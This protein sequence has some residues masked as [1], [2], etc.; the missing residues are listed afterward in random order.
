M[1]IKAV[2]VDEENTKHLIIGLNRD[3]INSL[4]DG[5]VFTLPR[6]TAITLTENSDLVLLF[7]ENGRGS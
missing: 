2:A 1:S 5:D 4:V 6:G 3:E 7:G